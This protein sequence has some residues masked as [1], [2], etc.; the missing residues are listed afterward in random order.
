MGLQFDVGD[1]VDKLAASL[2]VAKDQI[3]SLMP[4]VAMMRLIDNGVLAAV[5]I[6]VGA[7]LMVPGVR[8]LK[9]VL[10]RG[11]DPGWLAEQTEAWIGGGMVV[12]SLALMLVS[13][14]PLV[15]FVKWLVAPDAMFAL[16]AIDQLEKL[17]C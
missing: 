5:L 16:Y 14:D 10:A 6:V 1:A 4:Q 2:G 13:I 15:K 12:V 8:L 11:S 3:V 17:M 9:S 7:L